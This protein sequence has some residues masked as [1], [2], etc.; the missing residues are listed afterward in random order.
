MPSAAGLFWS[1]LLVSALVSPFLAAP[2]HAQ[3]VGELQVR[4]ATDLSAAIGQRLLEVKV[5]T[6]G[7]LWREAPRLRS[8]RAGAVFSPELVRRGLLELESTGKYAE[9]DAA[10]SIEEGGVRLVYRVRPRRLVASVR[11]QGS[12]GDFGGSERALGLG[13][14]DE[15]T[16]VI[17][18]RAQERVQKEYAEAG[19]PD[20]TVIVAAQDTDDP[21]RKFVRVTIE[22]GAPE[23]LRQVEFKVLPSPAHPELVRLLS[24]FT[25]RAGHRY[26]R[27][28]VT[29][30]ALELSKRLHEARFY[31]AEVRT[32]H[33]SLGLL[34]VHVDS[35]PKF[36]VRIE[37]SQAFG[38]P[39]LEQ[40]LDLAEAGEPD[41]EVLARRLTETYVRYGFFDARV[42]F[43]RRDAP[44]GLR[45]EL[46]GWVREG[47]RF[48]V[49]ARRFP[50]AGDVI[51][52]GKLESEVDGVLQEHFPGLTIGDPPNAQSLDLALG[53][54]DPT[55]RATP[56]PARPYASYSDE[57][58]KA[59]RQHL[60]DLYRAEGHLSATAGPVTL[61][62]RTCQASG[63]GIDCVAS[64][65]PPEP[66]VD[67][68]DQPSDAEA[69]VH[70]CVPDPERGIRCEDSGTV[71]IPI[72]PGPLAILHDVALSG[73]EHFT[74]KQLLAVAK[75]PLGRPARAADIQASL[76]RI[77]DLYADEAF[78]FAD[79]DSELEV[80]P[81]GT[82]VR[83]V[84]VVTE[85]ERV[86]V[87]RIEVRGAQRV[88][89]GV[90]RRRLALG[91]SDWYR[92]SAALRSQEQIESLGMFTSVSIALEDPGI[93][94]KE[95]VVVVTVTE[96]RPQYVDIKGGFASADGFRIGFEYGHRN[97]AGSAIQLS[98][99]SQLGLRPVIFIPEDDVRAKY[100]ALVQDRGLLGLL[101]RRNSISLTFPEI[102]LGP[103]YRLEAEL[104]D[105]R[106]NNRDFGL[107]KDATVLQLTYRPRQD[108][109]LQGGGTLERNDAEI[110]GAAAQR[111]S[112][113]EYVRDNP[114]LANTVRVP[115]GLSIAITQN[116]RGAWDR[117]DRPLAAR[118]GTYVSLGVEHVTA[119][120]QGELEGECNK[121]ATSVFAA[122]C[123][124]L[125]RY[126]GR[127]AGYVQLSQRGLTLAISFR[128]GIIQ[129]LTELSRTYPDRLFF[130]GGG[131]T[132][133]GYPQDSLVPQDLAERV[134]DPND[135]LQITDVV[136]RGGD[137]FIGP[138]MELR[139]PLIGSLE[140]AVFLDTGNVWAN[141]AHFDLF[142]LRYSIGT[143]IRVD[144]P[145]GPLVFDYGFNVERVLQELGFPVN[146]R[147]W[148]DIGAFHFS[149]GLF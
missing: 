85:R 5:E 1:L 48:T 14:D 34:L 36:S 75:L 89:L 131:D 60:E 27:E 62:R 106:D 74:E 98:I 68:R 141:P 20:A 117:R 102:G 47:R 135:G 40:Q 149:I 132:I 44:D 46:V 80:S 11:I 124:E 101:E 8:V 43:E 119:I 128:G 108:F 125:L 129:H 42:R 133:R 10:V 143:G 97:L 130:L 137:V 69:V 123:S 24:R 87:S 139:I 136:L 112:L 59:V 120:P 94:A 93:P 146:G 54:P 32:A 77:V 118:R 73:N 116:I 105:I 21:T 91:A 61:V 126:T 37:G 17:L 45:S 63:G 100:E 13:P 145:V 2:A 6:L 113:D 35:G 71:T 90:I 114:E 30:A 121:D 82:R 53:S 110:F 142:V 7:A 3:T 55:P 92:R 140:T 72:R 86:R 15:I 122:P 111:D 138:R 65:A 57:A 81:D 19:Y 12:L 50:C 25:V 104:L 29:A 16:D 49:T 84:V 22:S 148:E 79:V 41:T 56:L 31:Q 58:S 99:R 76:D 67:C 18:Q 88:E 9:L 96:R 95:K 78:A 26:S 38:A 64:G 39:E 107:T 103:R 33:P 134:M 4:A 109:Y 70:T 83:L 28:R 147:P 52:R 66:V 51:G 144:T 115:E 127:I 23:I